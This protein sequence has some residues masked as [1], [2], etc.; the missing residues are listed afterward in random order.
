MMHDTSSSLEISE[1][2]ACNVFAD[3][4]IESALPA[5]WRTRAGDDGNYD[6]RQRHTTEAPP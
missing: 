2:Y 3:S 1:K 4:Q 5:G 6:D